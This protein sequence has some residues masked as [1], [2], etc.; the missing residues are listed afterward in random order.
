MNTPK[1]SH[2][3]K[4]SPQVAS[5]LEAIVQDGLT[6]KTAFIENAVTEQALRWRIMRSLFG[7]SAEL[8]R[9]TLACKRVTE[10]MITG[11][12]PIRE[13][14]RSIFTILEIAREVAEFE[15]VNDPQAMETF[16]EMVIRLQSGLNELIPDA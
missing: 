9:L 2:H 4:L 16:T 5:E 14:D 7:D 8:W 1:I 6:T 3:V 11:L 10:D 12:N 13:W 15:Q